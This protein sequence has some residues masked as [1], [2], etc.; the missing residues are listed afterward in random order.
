MTWNILH[1]G[2]AARLPGIAL[3]ILD[4]RP[5]LVVLTEFRR[6]LGDQLR[7]VL[8]DHGL[9]HQVCSDPEPGVNGVLI[10]S[11]RPAEPMPIEV[12]GPRERLVGCRT[13]G[14][15]V[16]GVHTPELTRQTASRLLWHDL[17]EAARA[18]ADQD[19]LVIGDFNAERWGVDGTDRRR[20]HRGGSRLMGRLQSLGFI[21]AWRTMHPGEKAA[22]WVSWRGEGYRLDHAFLS[23]SLGVLLRSCR[24]SH[25]EL[26]ARLSDHAPLVLE[27]SEGKKPAGQGPSGPPGT[28]NPSKTV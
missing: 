26:E 11:R 18:H 25:G 17:T 24:F 22:S 20:A 28:K 2:G 6:S 3:A 16:I 19:C 21:D 7:G 12:A 27:L 4:H 8:A 15:A 14:I 13:R 9:E 1:G 5:D 10:A 23:R